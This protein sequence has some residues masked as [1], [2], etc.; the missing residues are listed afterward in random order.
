MTTG[1]TLPPGFSAFRLGVWALCFSATIA[2]ISAVM[3]FP[4]V[5]WIAVAAAGACL[6]VAGF[7][8]V[9]GWGADK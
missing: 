3:G 1:Q 5:G 4:T 7:A 6:F 9:Y 8:V 2:L